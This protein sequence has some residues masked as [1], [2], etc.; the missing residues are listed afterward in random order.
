MTLKNAAANLPYGGGKS[1]I[2]SRNN[3]KGAD[4]KRV[5]AAFARMIFRYKDVY[6]P[7]PDVG[8]ND[9][10]M[11]TI[12][13]TNGL[14]N[15]LSKPA[16]MGGNRI[17]ELGA[18]AEG[19]VIALHELLTEMPKLSKMV[20]FSDLKVPKPEQVTVITQGFGA[21]G[22]NAAKL[23]PQYLPGAK[24]VGISDAQ[25]YLYNP[26][27]LPI[28]E[29]YAGWK[30]EGVA[31]RGYFAKN[32]DSLSPD[33][34]FGSCPAD[35]LRE[36]AF[37]LIPATHIPNYIETTDLVPPVPPP[38]MAVEKMG[39][40]RVII[41]GANT[42]SPD[43]ARRKRRARMERVVYR[44]KGVL[45]AT[46]YLVNSGGVIFAAHERLIPAADKLSPDEAAKLAVQRREAAHKYRDEV[47]RRN[48][49][50]LVDMLAAHPDMLPCD[51]A[52]RIALRR[53]VACQNAKAISHVMTDMPRCLLSDTIRHAAAVMVAVSSPITAVVDSSGRLC[54]VLTEWDITK[55]MST[56]VVDVTTAEKVMTKEVV[57]AAPGE[58]LVSVVKKL[59][60]NE[61]SALPV[62]DTA[63]VVRGMIT[64]E[65]LARRS[66][67]NV[68]Q[69]MPPQ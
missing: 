26:Q 16:E 39:T 47:I 42:Y 60:F 23:V 41:E 17:D 56:G 4:R 48:M 53:I 55:A 22:A 6:L 38:V 34:K 69:M 14:N 46:D 12:A 19:T 3:L 54:G 24:V 61:L 18:A 63:G 40:W 45:I 1:G 15:A 11:G 8:T 43:P 7:G 35:L 50:E 5:I 51:A 66:L 44:N 28:E 57:S 9:Q 36:D 20:I 27:G 65:M 37:C 2:V 10:D 32:S 33:C 29:L 68:L 49:R 13:E 62:V 58:T 30:A 31:T 52:E 67:L 25:G 21:V 64:S 59:E